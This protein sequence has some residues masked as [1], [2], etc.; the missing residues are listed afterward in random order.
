[1]TG[2]PFRFGVVAA[3]ARTGEEWADRARRIESL[4]YSSLVMPDGLRYTLA[5]FPALAFAAA[6]T[7]SL[8]VGTYVIANDFRNPVLL[9][10][11]AATLDV[12]S[13]GRFEL[14]LG[15]GRPAAAEDNRMMGLGFD[16]G[17]VRVSRLAESLTLVR[18]LLAGEMATASGPYYAAA[19]AEVS[20][21]SAQ[22]P[23]ILVAGSGRRLLS[24]A[25]RE[26]DIVALGVPP[27]EPEEAAAEKVGWLR[28]A[29]GP[30]FDLLELNLNLMAVG[31]QVPR[32]ISAQMGLTAAGLAASGSV[33]AVTGTTDEMC[34]TLLR[35]RERLGISYLMVS[36]ELME[37]F[38]PVVER[39]AGR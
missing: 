17:G 11:E 3:V 35:R 9:A 34:A 36:D 31:D 22:R 10:K 8:R 38:A 23:P 18:A 24:L 27:T 26:A 15:A 30:R 20:P 39:L 33:A 28:E 4:G 1:M 14:G 16:A 7:R 37:V 21:R 25:A 12:L 19:G 29:A 2:H 32:Y 13:G 6:A 5:P